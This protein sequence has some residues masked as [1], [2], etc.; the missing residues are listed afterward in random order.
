MLDRGLYQFVLACA[1]R[2]ANMMNEGL[3]FSQLIG[4]REK[5][6]IFV[7]FLTFTDVL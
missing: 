7:G 1:E 3:S 6:T 2:S 5:S 4:S